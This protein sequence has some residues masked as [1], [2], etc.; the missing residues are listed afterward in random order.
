VHILGADTTRGDGIYSG[1]VLSSMMTGDGFY[2]CKVTLCCDVVILCLYFIRV[3][4]SFIKTGNCMS[5][6]MLFTVELHVIYYVL[7]YSTSNLVN[8]LDKDC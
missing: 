5:C 3:V 6:K 1:V 2:S 8:Y 7:H 4:F